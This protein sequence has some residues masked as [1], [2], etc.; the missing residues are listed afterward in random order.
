MISNF[1]RKEKLMIFV[2][3]I[4]LIGL[5]YYRFVHISVNNAIISADNEAQALQTELDL[6]NARLNRIK[7]A[8]DKMGTGMQ[9]ME[10]Y[11]GSKTETAF[12]NTVLAAAT[13]YSVTFDDVTREGNQIRRN[14]HLKY[15][16]ANYDAAMSIMKDLTTGE[17]RCLVGDMKCSIDKSGITTVD[18][19]GTFYETMVGGTKD[20]A[21][22]PDK[23]EETTTVAE[24]FGVQ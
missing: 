2:L 21:L 17:Y 3:A 22:P 20:S 10:S 7:G 23:S 18:A 15:T 24:D 6:A 13:D 14:F 5:I 19:S 1:S 9:R 8:K 12:L 11:N 4:L 16:A